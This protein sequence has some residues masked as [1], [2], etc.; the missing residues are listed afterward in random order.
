MKQKVAFQGEKGAYS[1][2]ATMKYFPDAELI[3]TKTFQD[4]FWNIESGKIDFAIIPIENSIE[5]SVNE[6]YR[7]IV[8]IK[9][10]CIWRNTPADNPL[11]Y[12]QSEFRFGYYIG[13]LT[14]SSPCTV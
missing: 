14:S 4:I 12:R 7:L 6:A 10:F 1:E 8:T 3:P 5:G 2:I 13:I 11:S 9:C